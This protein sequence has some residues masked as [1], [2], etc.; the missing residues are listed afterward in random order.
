MKYSRKSY[1][2]IRAT[3]SIC[4]RRNF[5]IYDADYSPDV[6]F[7]SSDPKPTLG[8]ARP[9][10]QLINFFHH[11]SSQSTV[12]QGVS[13]LRQIASPVAAKS[14]NVYAAAPQHRFRCLYLSSSEA[15]RNS[16]RRQLNRS[17][18]S[19]QAKDFGGKSSTFT[20]GKGSTSSSATSSSPR[21][22]PPPPPPPQP[23]TF[24]FFSNPLVW[25][26]TKLESHP[27]STKCITSG[28][29]A[30]SGDFLCQ[31]F[32]Y[33]NQISSDGNRNS[34]SIKSIDDGTA[35]TASKSFAP[36]LIRT[37]RFGIL[38]FC[39]VAP[40][41][42]LWYSTLII[43]FPGKT[44]SAVVKRTFFDQAFFSPIFLPTFMINLM[45]LEG[46]PF[47]EVPGKLERELPDALVASWCLWT[48][49]M[50]INFGF[51]PLKYQVLYSN[52]VGFVWNTYLSYKTQEGE[53]ENQEMAE[54]RM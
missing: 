42:H 20:S 13:M 8:S 52:M 49:A 24:S 10:R 41:V 9:Y 35:P 46:R 43:R 3:D 11:P 5:V 45:L 48:P 1:A 29:I 30:A 14:S 44:F 25:Y 38:G 28:I 54:S 32:V 33:K 51:V 22:P 37:G 31:Y 26:S 34:D 19:L 50:L 23:T 2:I 4:L 27:M 18:R 15:A 21:P 12:E 40:V 53:E 47:A 39:L 36:D 17:K 7:L 16:Q 6:E